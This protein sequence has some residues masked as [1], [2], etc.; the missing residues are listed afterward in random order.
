M[1]YCRKTQLETHIGLN[2][3]TDNATRFDLLLSH[4]LNEDIISQNKAAEL[5][6]MTLDA[7]LTKYYSN[8]KAYS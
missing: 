5:A 4:A 7:F 3:S 2:C 8:D 6:F 1:N